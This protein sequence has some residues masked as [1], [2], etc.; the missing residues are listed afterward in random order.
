MVEGKERVGFRENQKRIEGNIGNIFGAFF[1][2][3]SAEESKDMGWGVA[4][5]MES[6]EGFLGQR[7]VRACV[8]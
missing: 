8:C 7:G 2:F 5:K 1:F 4:E 3:F 6:K